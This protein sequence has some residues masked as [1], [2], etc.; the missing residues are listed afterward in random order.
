MRLRSRP[1]RRAQLLSVS[2]RCSQ[3]DSQAHVSGRGSWCSRLGGIARLGGVVVAKARGGRGAEGVPPRR[4]PHVLLRSSWLERESKFAWPKRRS[5]GRRRARRQTPSQLG[6]TRQPMRDRTS[7]GGGEPTPLFFLRFSDGRHVVKKSSNKG[8]Q[9]NA[10]TSP[11][12]SFL[13]ARMSEIGKT[14][15][16]LASSP[17]AT[18]TILARAA[19]YSS[20]SM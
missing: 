4:R 3:V 1:L 20:V 7:E 12:A 9:D 18:S 16:I 13:R 14:A 2:R 6:D 5:S 10:T 8:D 19:L 17:P 11:Q 15:C